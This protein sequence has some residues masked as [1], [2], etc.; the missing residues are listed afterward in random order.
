[1]KIDSSER[2]E[3]SFKFEAFPA[4]FRATNKEISTSEKI[5]SIEYLESSSVFLTKIIAAIWKINSFLTFFL[6]FF[7]FFFYYYHYNSRRSID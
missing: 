3:Q 2:S 1:M 7:F 5:C 6:L 4:Y